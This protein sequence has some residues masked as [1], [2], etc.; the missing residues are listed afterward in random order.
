MIYVKMNP[1]MFDIHLLV[2]DP[3]LFQKNVY[4]SF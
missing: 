1:K 2:K 3:F 4:S